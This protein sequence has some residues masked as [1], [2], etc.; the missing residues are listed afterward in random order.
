MENLRSYQ[1]VKQQQ[2]NQ[3]VQQQQEFVIPS[4]LVFNEYYIINMNNIKNI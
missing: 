4:F 3:F 1:F 2:S